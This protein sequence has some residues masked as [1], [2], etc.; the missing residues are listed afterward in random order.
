MFAILF[1]TILG[2]LAGLI[3]VMVKRRIKPGFILGATFLGLLSAAI[4]KI[5]KRQQDYHKKKNIYI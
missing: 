5:I 3:Y 4:Y 2:F 1:F